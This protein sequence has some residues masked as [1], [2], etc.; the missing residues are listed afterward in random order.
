MIEPAPTP[1]G[2]LLIDKPLGRTSMDVCRAVRRR[3]V[4]A[5][6]PKRVKVGHAGT[7]DPLATGLLIILVG[8]STRLC[9]TLMQGTKVYIADVDLSATT[10]T[11]DREGARTE[12]VFDAERLRCTQTGGGGAEGDSEEPPRFRPAA[13]AA[14]PSLA[15]LRAACDQFTGVIHQTPP[16]FSAMKVGGRR[17]YALARKGVDVQLAPRPIRIDSI[18]IDDY[19]W[20]I[21]RLTIVC[22]KGTYIR[23]LARDLGAALGV[24]G[25]LGALRRTRI[26]DFDIA[27][28]RTLADLPD[29]LTQADLLLPDA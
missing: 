9:D 5:G 16:A 15:D 3:L 26:G 19:T 17:A 1:S 14:P 6:A 23:S 7:L 25:T 21:A 8:K 20:P 22:G 27:Q 29:T 24:G 10:T 18:T 2:L 4:L 13:R 12:V 11:D 28:A